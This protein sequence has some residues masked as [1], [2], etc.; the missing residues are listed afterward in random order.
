M[1]SPA[2]GDYYWATG[3]IWN[4]DGYSYPWATSFSGLKNYYEDNDTD[5]ANRPSW[6]QQL[7]YPIDGI[8]LHF[9][10]NS[11]ED[12]ESGNYKDTTISAY[13]GTTT[14]TPRATEICRFW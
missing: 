5:N 12:L 2:F 8:A 10:P 11:L 1:Y 13:L 7:D 6:G 4:P 3:N 9:Y 14:A